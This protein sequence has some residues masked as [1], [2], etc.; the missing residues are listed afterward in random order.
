MW[1]V[2]KCILALPQLFGF[3]KNKDAKLT[4]VHLEKTFTGDNFEFSR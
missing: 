4:R 3:H 1:E 2:T